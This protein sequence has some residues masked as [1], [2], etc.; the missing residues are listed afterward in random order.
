MVEEDM[1]TKAAVSLLRDEVEKAIHPF[2]GTRR[3]FEWGR[4]LCLPSTVFGCARLGP[5][6]HSWT[7][8]GRYPGE[9]HV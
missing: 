4:A 7:I 9:R 6:V 2:Y 5:R 1:S 3:V 8:S